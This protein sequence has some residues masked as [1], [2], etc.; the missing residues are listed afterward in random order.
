VS[1]CTG[2]HMLKS[3]IVVMSKP[4]ARCKHMRGCKT[5]AKSDMTLLHHY[6]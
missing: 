3:F 1:S 2:I 6:C 5:V 4:R